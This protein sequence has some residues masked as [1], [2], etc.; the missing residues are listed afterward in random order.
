M[1]YLQLQEKEREQLQT[2]RKEQQQKEEA[3]KQ[4]KEAEQK[5]ETD[6][7]KK[8]A[9]QKEEKENVSESSEGEDMFN[10]TPQKIRPLKTVGLASNQ[11]KKAQ[12]TPLSEKNKVVTSHKV[13]ITYVQPSNK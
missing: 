1:S 7:Q 11:R 3:D 5:L 2:G 6:K 9:E 12:V 4:Q 13:A 8:E 10:D